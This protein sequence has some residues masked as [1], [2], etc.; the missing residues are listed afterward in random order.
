MMQRVIEEKMRPVHTP[1]HRAFGLPWDLLRQ[2]ELD[3]E[4]ELT[5][6]L[7]ASSGYLNQPRKLVN[8]VPCC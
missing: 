2:S 6:S 3:E 4:S 8:K 5:P 1:S 7:E